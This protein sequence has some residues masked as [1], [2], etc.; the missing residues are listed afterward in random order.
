[1]VLRRR[2][3]R[4]RRTVLVDVAPAGEA[5]LNRLAAHSLKALR[6]EGPALVSALTRLIRGGRRAAERAD[7]QGRG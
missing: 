1:M 7:A 6:T 5:V 3:P 4:D 2:D